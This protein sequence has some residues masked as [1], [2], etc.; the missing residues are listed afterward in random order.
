MP[1]EGAISVTPGLCLAV[2]RGQLRA[3]P[4]RVGAHARRCVVIG[5]MTD[6]VGFDCRAD[7]Q[8]AAVWRLNGRRNMPRPAANGSAQVVHLLQAVHGR[9]QADLPGLE[10][11]REIQRVVP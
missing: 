7:A 5:S 4:R 2:R 10:L 6:V 9:V 11:E 8:A 1:G 3:L